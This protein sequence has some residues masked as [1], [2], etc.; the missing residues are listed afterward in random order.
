MTNAQR[1]DQGLVVTNNIRTLRMYVNVWI[2]TS[3]Y[4]HIWF[5][6]CTHQN[7]VVNRLNAGL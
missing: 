5:Q 2:L 6:L 7:Y 3:T 1:S 4:A